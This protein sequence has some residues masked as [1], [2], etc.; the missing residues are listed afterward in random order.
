MRLVPRRPFLLFLPPPPCTPRL[1]VEV[2]HRVES[3]NFS[4]S[5]AAILGGYLA[6][7]SLSLPIYVQTAVLF[8]SIPLSLTLV[9]PNTNK[10]NRVEKSFSS[11]FNI[12][13]YAMIENKKGMFVYINSVAGKKAYPFSSA[14]VTSK[15]GLRGFSRSV[16]EEFRDHGIKVVSI[17]PGAVDTGFWNKLNVDFP[18]REMMSC[19]NIAKSIAHCIEAPDNLVIEEI[20]IQRIKGEF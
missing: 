20:D 4:E 5:I 13:K 11:M 16:R 3:G 15:F 8:F 17:H 19:E 10:K 14:Y 6:L 9:E 12:M 18:R 1:L 2:H 7:T